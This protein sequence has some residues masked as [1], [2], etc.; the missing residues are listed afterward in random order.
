MKQGIQFNTVLSDNIFYLAMQGRIADVKTTS[1]SY[2][3]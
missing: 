3:V 1:F 2:R